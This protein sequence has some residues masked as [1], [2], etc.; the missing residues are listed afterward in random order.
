MP[1]ASLWPGE[2][3]ALHPA[4]GGASG[5]SQER[6]R[7]GVGARPGECPALLSA[8][9]RTPCAPLGR[10]RRVN[11]LRSTRR[12]VNALRFTR[13]T[14][15]VHSAAPRAAP[16]ASAASPPKSERS[17]TQQPARA[18][19]NAHA[20]SGACAYSLVW[21]GGMMHTLGM[22]ELNG[23]RS[24]DMQT[25]AGGGGVVVGESAARAKSGV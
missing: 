20:S 14:G 5:L 22:S 11:A 16:R 17:S 23:V 3:L 19:S 13:M 8:A 7:H 4:R 6:D 1:C 10:A 18:A 2:C 21:V 24:G 9:G 25:F 15:G 12:R